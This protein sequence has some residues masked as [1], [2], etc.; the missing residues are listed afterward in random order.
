MKIMD[1]T[2]RD[3]ANVLGNGFPK[4]LTVMMLKGLTDNG[5]SIIEY[6]NAK[7]LG[8][9][10]L[11]FEGPVSDAEYLELVQPFLG[12]A[13]IGMFLNAKRYKK[14]N[15][16]HAA[17]KGLNF[18]RVG[19]DAGDAEKYAEVIKT[20]KEA[21][22]TCRYSLMKAYILTPEK[23][24]EEAK[25]LEAM[26]VDEMTI[27]DSAGCMLPD[28]VKEYV[29]ALKAVVKIPIGFHCHNNLGMSA[30]NALAAM[31]S[32]VDVLDCGLLGM[33]RSA[34]NLATE[35]ATAL[36]KKYGEASEVDFYGLLDFLEKE[37]IPAMETHGYKTAIT[38]MELILG[39]SGC[40][41]SF[42][43]KFKEIAKE[44]GV[45]VKK[46]IVEVSKIDRKS[47]SEE[48]MRKMAE[49]MKGADA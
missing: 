44:Y 49:T 26:G 37:L 36:A 35:V 7:G 20:V 46:L 39:Y 40:H 29:K 38:P 25:K 15:V 30:A 45:D 9:E 27:M 8:A 16:E 41:S 22:L 18:L 33:A 31:Q 43:K 4:Y 12:K 28:E 19:A 6:G 2:M 34:G 1:C 21:G 11:G 13:E 47:P 10:N 42:V 32:G 17:A 14:E 3:G 23:L 48:L 24:A 5:V